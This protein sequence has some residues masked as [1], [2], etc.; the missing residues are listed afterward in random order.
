VDT[1][2]K[3]YWTSAQRI[4]PNSDTEFVWKVA[5]SNG[6]VVQLPMGYTR[7]DQV[8]GEPHFYFMNVGPLSC[9]ILCSGMDYY[10]VSEMCMDSDYYCSVCE[11]D[12]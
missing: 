11:I 4:D 12:P 2:G 8:L 10:W 6:T 1:Y 7:W 3:C 9:V 5:L